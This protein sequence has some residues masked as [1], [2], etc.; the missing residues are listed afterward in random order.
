MMSVFY[1][2]ANRFLPELKSCRL[3]PFSIPRSLPVP[4]SAEAAHLAERDDYVTVRSE[5]D[6]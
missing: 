4:V 2:F 6:S 1:A 5:A 3:W